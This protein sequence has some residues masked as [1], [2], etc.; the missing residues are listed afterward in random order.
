MK[1]GS[2]NPCLS[3]RFSLRGEGAPSSPCRAPASAHPLSP[4]WL[5]LT[6]R[7]EGREGQACRR[8]EV[9]ECNQIWKVCQR[10]MGVGRPSRLRSR[11][12]KGG[13]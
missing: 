6:V 12:A 9:I 7:T 2:L 3:S 10:W 13:L 11:E 8:E 4:D 5:Q 1:A